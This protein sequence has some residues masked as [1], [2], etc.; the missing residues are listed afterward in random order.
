MDAL[1]Q[2]LIIQLGISGLI[3][4]VGY[5]I[6]IKFIEAWS[7][8]EAERTKMTA[9]AEAD[10][11]KAI[12][13]G[14]R[15]DIDAHNAIV[16]VLQ[17]HMQV[18]SRV[19][20]KLDAAFDYTPVRGQRDYELRERPPDSDPPIPRAIPSR[21]TPAKGVPSQGAYG[22]DKPPRGKTNG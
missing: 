14:F 21:N 6:A 5:K 4:F 18:L 12:E 3:V 7:R 13:A 15:S 16:Q 8:A 11:T 10:R 17:R 20:G 1:W 9:A 22:P 2:Q 19:E